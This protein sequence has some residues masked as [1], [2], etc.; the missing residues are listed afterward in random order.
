MFKDTLEDRCFLNFPPADP[1]AKASVLRFRAVSCVGGKGFPSSG[2]LIPRTSSLLTIRARS[3]LSFVLCL[4]TVRFSVVG[5]H[6]GLS[7]ESFASFPKLQLHLHLDLEPPRSR[8]AFASTLCRPSSA[9]CT[10]PPPLNQGFFS[11]RWAFFQDPDPGGL[12]VFSLS[13][14]LSL[15][16]CGGSYTEIQ[17]FCIHTPSEG[18]PDPRL[19][20]PWRLMPRGR[21]H[22][23]IRP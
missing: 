6:R 10:F 21:P 23:L 16:V 7:L 14:Q 18:G 17:L 2:R 20:S 22:R 8:L 5:H 9:T 19:L 3:L 4:T 1:S 12:L 13:F 15:P 11:H